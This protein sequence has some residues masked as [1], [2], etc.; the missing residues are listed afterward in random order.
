MSK[1]YNQRR[2]LFAI[3]KASFKS[4]FKSPSSTFFSLFFPIVLIIIFG[5]LGG[6]GGVSFDVAIDKNSD[7][8]NAIYQIITHSPLFTIVKGTQS[9][10]ED[11]LKKGRITA[12]LNVQKSDSGKYDVHIKSSSAGQ[13]ELP[14]LQGV[15]NGVI[16][17]KSQE[18][19]PIEKIATLSNEQVEGRVY[20]R[21]DFYLPGMIGFSL[22]GS[23]VFGVAFLFFALRETLVLKRMYASP[24]TKTNIVLGESLG[25]VFFQLLI[26]I[27]LIIFGKFAYGFTL[28]NGVV[29]FIE[30]LV[31]SALALIVFMGFGFFISSV[32]KNQNVIPIYANLFMFPQYFLSGTF[33][34]KSVLPQSIHWLIEALPLTALNDALRKVAFEGSH[35]NDCWKQIGI[36]GA[37][38]VVIYAFAIWVFRWE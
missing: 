28:A 38:G 29:T 19:H 37:W 33:F 31:L 22:I 16:N 14:Q 34:P 3:T 35:I 30:L 8:T 2:A 5:S 15:L 13:R 20:K 17:E 25:R 36:L 6:G 24:V 21:I 27:V 18:L 9:E 7:S 23:A 1:R 10:A 26:V 12:I 11:E 32:A 4:I